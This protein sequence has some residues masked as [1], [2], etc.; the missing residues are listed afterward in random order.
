MTTW[1][2]LPATPRMHCIAAGVV[3]TPS[4]VVS[5]VYGRIKDEPKARALRAVLTVP[6]LAFRIVELHRVID[7]GDK[8]F[9]Q[10]CTAVL[11]S[12]GGGLPNLRYQ[13]TLMATQWTVPII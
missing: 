6:A 4:D 7:G 9:Q 1:T 11:V 3:A 10:T 13:F 5:V 8:F 2:T 12:G